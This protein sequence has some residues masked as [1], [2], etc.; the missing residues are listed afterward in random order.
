M[1]K[2]I[3]AVC[4]AGLAVALSAATAAASASATIVVG[5]GQSIQAAVNRASPGDTVLIKPGVYRQSVQIRTDGITL[6]GSGAFSGGTVLAPPKSFPKTLCNSFF[7]P[8]G[9][10]ILAK[11]VNTST[12]AVL[13]PV[14]DDTVTGLLVKGFPGN[15]V[16]GYGTDGLQVTRVV[17]I[18][19]GGYGVSRFESTRTLFA[20]DIAIG[21]DEAGFYVGDSPDADTVVRD[22]QAYGNQFGIF[23]RHA[24]QVLVT[25]NRASGN[26][27][28][29]LVLDDGQAGG[30]GN[31]IIVANSV[32]ANNKFCPK[33]EDTPVSTQGGGIL[34]LGATR[35]VVAA[36][37]VH[38]NSGKQFNSG[39]IVVLSAHAISGG[40]NPNF[41][42]IAGNTAFGNHPA[43][44]VW[45]RTGTG[46]Q[47]KANHCGTSIPP[48]L[49]H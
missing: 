22:D 1:R 40:S 36:N 21:N 43:D 41:D 14:R 12:G 35:T 5:P 19:D 29:I 7:G 42:T 25:G 6:R 23:I 2:F 33:S 4:A 49:C 17:A 13:V 8:T 37:N 10:C 47:F 39:G 15:G 28:G 20:D 26:C 32:S 38:G 48:G 3:M 24:R 9:V 45:D 18:D 34:L 44:L 27:Q 31:A 11:A 46:V 16:F 30:A